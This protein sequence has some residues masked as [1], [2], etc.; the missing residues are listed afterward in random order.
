[1]AKRAR[2]NGKKD[3][4]R[5]RAPPPPTFMEQNWRLLAITIVVF[6]MV[7]VG[8][9]AVYIAPDDDGGNNPPPTE[10]APEFQVTTIDGEPIA[11]DQFRGKVV[12]LDLMATWCEPCS[13][14]MDELNQIR[15][16][17]PES[18]VVILSVGVDTKETDQQLRQ[19]KEQHYANWRFASDSDDVGTKYDASNIPT[20][21][22]IDQDGNLEWRHAGVTTA[23]DL[24]AKIDPL[25]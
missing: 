18:R 10:K 13:L 22:I 11:L 15:A 19:F 8:A 23:D 4:R 14:Q 6:M 7:A 12:I 16:S 25:M 24:R 17:Y 20:L 9:Y 3:G 1:M 2:R 21:A 5:R